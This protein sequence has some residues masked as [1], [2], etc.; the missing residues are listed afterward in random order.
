MSASPQ[1]VTPVPAV[2]LVLT[3]RASSKWLRDSLESALARDP[4]D[5]LN[6]SLL[7]ASVLE[8]QLRAVL[9]LKEL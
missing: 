9:G 3:D 4:V 7:L 6:D 8:A 1:F 5:A 2:A